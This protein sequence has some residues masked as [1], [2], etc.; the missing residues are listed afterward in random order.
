MNNYQLSRR[1]FLGGTVSGFFAYA[2]RNRCAAALTHSPQGQAQHCIVLW[3]NGG[4]SQLDTFD[5][6][7][8]TS[9]GGEFG[10]ISTSVPGLS[11]SETLPQMARHMDS[12][13]VLRS[14][15]SQEGEH[16]RAQYYL[17]T[18]YRLVP[19]F[20][21]PAAGSVVSHEAPPQPFPQFVT[22]GSEGFGPAY[23]GPA[24][25][26]F[27]IENA[28]EALVLLHRLR[29]KR[30]RMHLLDNLDEGF[31]RHHGGEETSRR[32]AMI[33]RIENMVTTPFVNALDVEREPSQNRQR[34]GDHEFGRAC[35]VARRLIES[36]VR[37]VEVQHDGWDTHANNFPAV[38]QLCEAIDRPWAALM[39]DL[40]SSGLFENTLIVWLGEFGRTPR[41]NANRGRDHFPRITPVVI[42]GGGVSAGGVVGRT[43][44]LGT[45]IESEPFDVADLFA[46]LFAAFGIDPARVFETSFGAPTTATDKGLP[47]PQLF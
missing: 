20:P 17:H 18:G 7:P 29:R 42:G 40:K 4:P 47:I 37:F 14:L 5:P 23:M 33:S 26:P 36:G 6:K 30:G 46:S 43:N 19:G 10:S 15:T 13:T 41:I 38:R 12:L 31:D 27:T 1:C 39:E 21:R 8:R 44:K 2:M 45:Q 22:L 16:L 11:I 24:H 3:M 9:T 34:Y 25:A 28:D 32:R 35:L